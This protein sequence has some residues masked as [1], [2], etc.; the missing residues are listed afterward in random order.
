MPAR[1][2]RTVLDEIAR[3]P[4]DTFLVERSADL[5]VRAQDVE[6]S[7]REALEQ[8]VDRLIGGP[9]A[10][11]L[12]G[13]AGHARVDEARDEQARAEKRAGRVAEL[14]LERLG[15]RLHGGLGHVV[16]GVA[17]GRRDALLRARVDHQACPAARKHARHEDLRAMEDAPEV[18]PEHLLPGGFVAEGV[19][20]L[21]HASVVHQHIGAAETL[22][23]VCLER[24]HIVDAR[25]VRRL[26]EDVG[27]TARRDSHDLALGAFERFSAKVGQHHAQTERREAAGGGEPDAG[28]GAGHDG[29]GPRLDGGMD[30]EGVDSTP[31]AAASRHAVASARAVSGEGSPNA[32]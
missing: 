14:V 8:K 11:G 19:G 29:N 7:G 20:L 13:S 26:G 23:H 18:H 28:G 9:R 6:V 21:G 4:K 25:D 12:L 32:A 30:H 10:R 24:A 1:E 22:G 17:R 5:V 15:V 16:R 27:R 31:T 2:R 3:G